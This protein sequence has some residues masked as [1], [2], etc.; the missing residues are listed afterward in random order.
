MNLST[1]END[2]LAI[3]SM[4]DNSKTKE[5]R[6]ILGQFATPTLLANQILKYSLQLT[7]NFPHI[8][9]LDPAIGTG[10]F[11]SALQNHY[12]S[13]RIEAASG[14][15][16]DA[17]V[18]RETERIW[19]GSILKV[20]TEDFTKASPPP[21]A[22]KSNLVICNPPYVRHHHL[23]IDDKVRLKFASEQSSGIRPNGLSGL[24]CYFM[25]ISHKWMAKDA[26]ACWLIPSEF[27]DVNYGAYLKD[28]LTTKVTL[29]DIHRF[30]PNEIQFHD[31]LVTSAVVWFRN[32]VPDLNDV[33]SFTYGANMENPAIIKRINISELKKRKKWTGIVFE[34]SSTK[35]EGGPLLS[36]LFYIK[37]GLATGNNK[38]FILD[39]TTIKQNMIPEEFLIPI[40]PSPRYLRIDEVL[41]DDRGYPIIEKP[42]FLLSC[43]LTEKVVEK[44]YPDLW[45]YYQTGIKLGVNKG[46]L[47]KGRSPWY[48][49]E[50]REAAP[51]LC[52][53][54]GRSGADGGSAFR[55]IR[56]HSK[57]IANNSY[58]CLYPKAEMKDEIKRD[59]KAFNDIWVD[60]RKIKA[61]DLIKEGRV[62]GGGLQKLEP[63]ELGRVSLPVLNNLCQTKLFNCVNDDEF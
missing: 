15:E 44:Q 14:Y 62:Y 61:S 16:I 56:N 37:R 2:R 33:V 21:D 59:P 8:R 3:Q 55:F 19:R 11:F 24:Y 28:Y 6:N 29:L 57:A 1:E 35:S 46:F 52:S 39:R 47:C 32:R 27:M 4:L 25:C 26:I 30:D 23:E 53:Y 36:D 60:L 9:F 17:D 13:D 48:S 58:L 51:I 20:Y 31:A 41:K 54:M 34:E 40:L 49:Q 10:S 38:F 18:T 22:E 7:K 42:L 12:P 5:E 45:K 43:D 50:K 63:K